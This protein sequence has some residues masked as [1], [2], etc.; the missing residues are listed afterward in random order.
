MFRCIKQ[1]R[2]NLLSIILILI[3]KILL[4]FEDENFSYYN[5]VFSTEASQSEF[6]SY[7]RKIFDKEIIDEYPISETV[8]GQIGK[9]R[10]SAT[11]YGSDD[12]GYLQ[13][14]LPLNEFTKENIYFNDYPSIFPDD[15]KLWNTKTHM[16]C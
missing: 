12:T 9:Y 13:V 4:F 16:V 11:H 5:I 15:R 3:L 14:Y 1:R 10:I 2:S 7:Y 8:K 6:L